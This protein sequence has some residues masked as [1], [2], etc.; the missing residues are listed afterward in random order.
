MHI[1]ARALRDRQTET[2]KETDRQTKT[3][4][5]RKKEYRQTNRHTDRHTDTERDKETIATLALRTSLCNGATLLLTM[6]FPPS[7][8]AYPL[9]QSK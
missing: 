2:E 5:D 1:E 9:H 7:P 3:E 8:L 4:T 6:Q